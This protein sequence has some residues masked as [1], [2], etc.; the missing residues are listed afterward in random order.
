MGAECEID[1][2]G[3]IKSVRCNSVLERLA[4]DNAKRLGLNWKNDAPLSPFSTDFG[5]LSQEIPSLYLKVPL[6]LG[7]FHNA[8]AIVSSK[9]EGAHEA[10]INAVKLLS[11]TAIDVLVTPDLLLTARNELNYGRV[12]E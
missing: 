6:G 10:M 9:S 2:E 5:N 7:R 12:T 8:E 1:E 3:T 4:G 11:L